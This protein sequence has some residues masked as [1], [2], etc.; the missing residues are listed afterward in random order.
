MGNVVLPIERLADVWPTS[1]RSP[2]LKLGAVLHPASVDSRLEHTLTALLAK[3]RALFRLGALFGPQHGFD[4]TTQDNMIEWEGG[5]HPELGV[6]LHSLYGEH[7]EPTEEMLA[8]IDAVFVDL[9]RKDG[10][11]CGVA[12]VGE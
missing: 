2:E 8:P 3:N 11:D 9:E 12:G 4:G 1:L 10:G 7:R 6:A 5:M